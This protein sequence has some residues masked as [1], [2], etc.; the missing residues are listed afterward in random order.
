MLAPTCR[1]PWSPTALSSR[2]V[3]VAPKIAQPVAEASPEPVSSRA[4]SA[5]SSSGTG[6]TASLSTSSVWFSVSGVLFLVW[7]FAVSGVLFWLAHVRGFGVVWGIAVWGFGVAPP[8][9]SF[10]S[11]LF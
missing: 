2:S 9:S 11:R 8:F 5:S 3:C 1:V 6:G 10:I 4:Q 7:G